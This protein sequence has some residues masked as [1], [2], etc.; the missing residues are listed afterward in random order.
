M[1]K[2][3]AMWFCLLLCSW[4][5][6][7]HAQE[8]MASPAQLQPTFGL[9]RVAALQTEI[10][11]Y[12]LW[13]YCASFIWVVLAFAVAQ[14]IDFLMTQ[15]LRRVTA[16]TRTDIDDKLIEVLHT[17]VKAAVTLVMLNAGVHVFKWP[18]WVEKI[19]ST[20]FAVAVG[21]TIIY[22]AL[23]LVDLLLI[24]VERKFFSGDAQTAR[25]MMPV[26]RKSLK[27]FVIII[28]ALTLAQYMGL[29]ITSVVAGLGIG[30]IAVA[31]AAQN[32]LANVFGTITILADRPFRVGDRVQIDK[33]DGTV[34]TIGLRS[35]RIRTLDGHLVTLPN[36]IVADSGI[37]NISLRP[38]IRQLFTISLTYDTTPEKMREALQIA[39]EVIGRHPLTHDFI[40]NWR[41]FGPHSLDI[42]VV[43]W[44]KT[45]DF[46]EFL[47]AL[48]EINLEL[49]AR[50]DARGL[51]FAFPTRTIH[52]VQ[53]SPS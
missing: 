33:F 5:V 49:K 24:V 4:P 38:N 19:L 32:T 23:R 25:L 39:R 41:D 3:I 15:Q 20:V 45:T 1:M 6:G 51:N 9:H 47:A 53:S 43:Y 11:G 27:V 12:P 18:E 22:L 28:G 36:K 13:Q 35:T 8:T 29:P 37:T 52:L 21:A 26:L 34:E 50:Y 48:E 16:R 14:L 44:A 46:K 30:G 17:P 7:G 10:G 31:L 2:R 40:V 42:F